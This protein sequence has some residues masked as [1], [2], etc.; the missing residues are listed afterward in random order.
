MPLV[1]CCAKITM[2]ETVR[3]RVQQ[4]MKGQTTPDLFT[5]CFT[6]LHF[7]CTSVHSQIMKQISIA[8]YLN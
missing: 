1:A 4:C 6:A 2:Q 3:Q 7:I 8:R 5:V